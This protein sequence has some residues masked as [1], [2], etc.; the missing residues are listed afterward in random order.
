MHMQSYTFPCADDGFTV[1]IGRSLFVRSIIIAKLGPSP[2]K[3]GGTMV[4][5]EIRSLDILMIS[6]IIGLGF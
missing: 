5:V 2:L 4:H 6:L 1:S 3:R